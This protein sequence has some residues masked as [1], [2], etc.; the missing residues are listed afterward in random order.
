MWILA[1]TWP[2]Q[3]KKILFKKYILSVYSQTWSTKRVSLDVGNEEEI[4]AKAMSDNWSSVE[5]EGLG[6]WTSFPL[7]PGNLMIPRL[8]VE[9]ILI[10]LGSETYKIYKALLKNYLSFQFH[11]NSW[12]YEHISR[13]VTW[14]ME[15][16][17]ATK[18]LKHKLH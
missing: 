15:G 16:C 14:T 1:N 2:L 10:F 6:L 18:A 12:W 5:Y 11:P 8:K 9:I 3:T 7:R 17:H 4:M 13:A